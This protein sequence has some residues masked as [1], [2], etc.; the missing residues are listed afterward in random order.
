MSSSAC[1]W[2]LALEGQT[3][4]TGHSDSYATD[5]PIADLV[6]PRWGGERKRGKGK[7]KDKTKI[8]DKIK[9]TMKNTKI[10][11]LMINTVRKRKFESKVSPNKK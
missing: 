6:L 10:E 3:I 5:T 2:C 11:K 7:G 1:Q 8:K 9:I 4:S